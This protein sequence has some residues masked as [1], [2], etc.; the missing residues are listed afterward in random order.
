MYR[1]RAELTFDILDYCQYGLIRG[2]SFDHLFLPSKL[3]VLSLDL[4]ECLSNLVS[5]ANRYRYIC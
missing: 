2:Y 3:V 1:E 5:M 4:T